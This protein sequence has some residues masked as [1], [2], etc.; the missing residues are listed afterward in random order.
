MNCGL[1]ITG[2]SATSE[3]KSK[4]KKGY[5]KNSGQNSKQLLFAKK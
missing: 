4:K 1:S 2:W 3:A 5:I